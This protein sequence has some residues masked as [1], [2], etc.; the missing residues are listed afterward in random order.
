MRDA[1]ARALYQFAK[2]DP[3]IF[4][5]VAD[6][7]P[8]GS[9]AQFRTEF[10][11]RFVNVGV[12]EQSMIGMCAGLAMRGCRPFAYTIA[13]FSIYRPFEYVRDDLCY[14]NLPVTV[15]GIGGGVAYSTLGGTH[16]AQEDIAMMSA[17]PNMSIVAPCDPRETEAAVGACVRHGGPVYLRLG[18]AGEPDLTANALEPFQFGKLRLLKEGSDVCLLSYG[19]MTALAFE[20]AA[21]LEAEGCSVAVMTCP[22]LKPLD[23]EGLVRVL[24]RFHTVVVVEEHSERGG[25][26]VQ[27][28]ALAW[29]SGASCRLETFSLKDAFIHFFGTQRQMWGEHGLTADAIY[30][31]IRA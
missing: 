31:R 19:P 30:T 24:R 3:R 27:V 10:P 13:T 8:A 12:A 18:K 29:E 23:T 17:L 26:A 16:H 11:E 21:R 9:M 6:I 22:T 7:S 2:Q 25:L 20:V 28:K 15:V 4:I 14:Q 5:I 1:F